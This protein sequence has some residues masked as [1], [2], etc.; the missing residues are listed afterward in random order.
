[1]IQCTLSI[2]TYN[3]MNILEQP[4]INTGFLQ[5]VQVNIL[6]QKQ[7]RKS[8][9]LSFINVITLQFVHITNQGEHIETSRINTG[10]LSICSNKIRCPGRMGLK[11][12]IEQ[13]HERYSG[14]SADYGNKYRE[15]AYRYVYTCKARAEI[16]RN[17][18]KH[19]YYH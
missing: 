6:K 5:F 12:H 11:E 17:Q 15:Q 8:S 4:R 10:F 19:T 9:V 13:K 7:T 16:D 14:N 3:Y 18:R 2:D 1:M